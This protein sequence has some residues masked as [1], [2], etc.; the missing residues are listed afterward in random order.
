MEVPRLRYIVLSA[1]FFATIC[2]VVVSLLWFETFMITPIDRKSDFYGLGHA[3]I[4]FGVICM[5]LST[6][7]IFL[8][9]IPEVRNNPFLSF[10]SFFLLPLLIAF[11]FGGTLF[12]WK[13]IGLFVVMALSFGAPL[14]FY[15]VKYRRRL[16]S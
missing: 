4:V 5:G 14:A 12:E 16:T 2:G 3:V 7:T 13:S 10:L 6:T 9:K 15:Y 8:N 11:F 1:A